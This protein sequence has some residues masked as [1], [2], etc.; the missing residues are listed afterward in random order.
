MKILLWSYSPSAPITFIFIE[1]Y[2]RFFLTLS[3]LNVAFLCILKHG[4]YSILSFSPLFSV[5]PTISSYSCCYGNSFEGRK[6]LW[7]FSKHFNSSLSINGFVL[8]LFILPILAQALWILLRF[9]WARTI[10]DTFLFLII[11]SANA[12]LITGFNELLLRGGSNSLGLNSTGWIG[13]KRYLLSEGEQLCYATIQLS[14]FFLTSIMFK[15]CLFNSFMS[16]R[17][18]AL[19]IS[20]ITK[21]ESL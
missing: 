15:I 6:N 21:L 9:Y 8:G 4:V 18:E 3:L 1:F 17:T 13:W 2:R 14:G 19:L 20:W 16:S 12:S 5:F 10:P 11:P 7:V